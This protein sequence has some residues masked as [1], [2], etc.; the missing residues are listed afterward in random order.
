MEAWSE[1]A[2]I[3]YPFLHAWAPICTLRRCLSTKFLRRSSVGSLLKV[4]L[5]V[6]QEIKFQLT[7]RQRWTDPR[8][9]YGDLA[10]HSPPPFISLVGEDADRIWTP[11]T[12]V[13]ESREAKVSDWELCFI[14][15]RDVM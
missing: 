1:Y 14:G 13:R 2:H 8:L 3:A 12:F 15:S 4:A 10:G 11:D 5:L 6:G 9:A 7:L